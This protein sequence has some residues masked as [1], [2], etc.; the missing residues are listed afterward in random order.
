MT[1]EECVASLS[2]VWSYVTGGT[3]SDCGISSLQSLVDLAEL[4]TG[5]EMAMEVGEEA[6]TETVLLRQWLETITP[7]T[8]YGYDKIYWH[9]QFKGH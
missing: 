1:D 9:T 6:D 3:S 8:R 5:G 4:E 2:T 7:V